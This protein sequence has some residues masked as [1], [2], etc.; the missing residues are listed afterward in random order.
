MLF[1]G[2]VEASLGRRVKWI[3]ALLVAVLTGVMSVRGGAALHKAI[4]KRGHSVAAPG[5]YSLNQFEMQ[6]FVVDLAAREPV[7]LLIGVEGAGVQFVSIDTAQFEGFTP[8]ILFLEDDGF[9]PDAVAGDGVFTGQMNPAQEE[10]LPSGETHLAREIRLVELI[11][12]GEGAIDEDLVEDVAYAYG[13]IDGTEEGS[14]DQSLETG[15]QW[16][17]SDRVL[18]LVRPGLLEGSF[19]SIWVDERA[20][21]KNV[22]EIL[23][24][25]FDWIVFCGVYNFQAY[26]VS[27]HTLVRNAV[28][29]IGQRLFDDS[30]AFGSH[31]VLRSIVGLY[32]KRMDGLTH[33]LFHTWGVYGVE[34][35]GLRSSVGGPGHWGALATPGQASVFGFPSSLDGFERREDG[36]FCG[37]LSEGP[38]LDWERYLMGLIPADTVQDA[39]FVR[40]SELTGF[41]CGGYSFSG[42]QVETLSMSRWIET[43]GKREPA[44]PDINRFKAA[45]VVVSDR[46]LRAIEME[47][48]ARLAEAHE[49]EYARKHDQA[50]FI[51][52]S[53][54]SESPRELHGIEL[55]DAGVAVRLSGP[56]GTLE[57]ETSSD[58]ESWSTFPVEAPTGEAVV[59]QAASG[60]S[61]SWFIRW[62]R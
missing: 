3:V 36:T 48:F 56:A 34:G 43:F 45:M 10:S 51:S 42:D 23:G 30:G 22:I 61:A 49:R 40:N 52:Y 19:P 62:K 57:L 17:R 27:E 28:K 58:L 31:G 26:P 12:H 54:A 47:Y 33:N 50:A 60:S 24:D 5:N 20:A 46:A 44:Y 2:L 14:G 15:D 18:N 1:G 32:Q 9:P 21:S 59:R 7:N 8:E 35:L 41:T 39:H 25:R 4:V 53:L 38:M 16:V 37:A 11:V 29:G 55:T 6:P 13:F